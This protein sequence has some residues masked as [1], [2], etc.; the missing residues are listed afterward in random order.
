MGHILLYTSFVKIMPS[1]MAYLLLRILYRVI[2]LWCGN[3]SKSWCVCCVC[4]GQLRQ[5]SGISWDNS[6]KICGFDLYFILIAIPNGPSMRATKAVTW[7]SRL[8]ERCL[9]PATPSPP[10]CWKRKRGAERK[11]V[12]GGR[13]GCNRTLESRGTRDWYII[14]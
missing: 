6:L 4:P 3:C 11:Y 7:R 5:H 2:Q 14:R 13:E 10:T 1:A 8:V 12:G 9:L